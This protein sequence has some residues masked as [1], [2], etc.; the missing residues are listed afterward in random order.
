VEPV[1][2][3]GG[4]LAVAVDE[5]LQPFGVPLALAG[6][7]VA[8]VVDVGF[9]GVG[10]ADLPEGVGEVQLGLVEQTEVVRQVHHASSCRSGSATLVTRTAQTL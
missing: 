4:V 7:G 2:L 8:E 6:Q 10:V 9:G 5:R 1:G 3:A